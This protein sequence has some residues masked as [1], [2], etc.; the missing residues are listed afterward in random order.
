MIG[1]IEKTYYCCSSTRAVMSPA[2][3]CLRR[4][5]RFHVLGTGNLSTATDTDLPSRRDLDTHV[6]I[7]KGRSHQNT[8]TM[9]CTTYSMGGF[10]FQLQCKE[11]SPLTPSNVNCPDKNSIHQK[12]LPAGT[13]HVTSMPRAASAL[14]GQQSLVTMA[15]LVDKKLTTDFR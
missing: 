15:I 4:I 7:M 10:V 6:R 13:Y 1:V 5:V 11:L 8:N 12:W 14:F 9:P 3:T 2:T